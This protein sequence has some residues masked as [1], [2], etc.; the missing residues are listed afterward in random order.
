MR[1]RTV[2][3]LTALLLAVGSGCRTAPNE[4]ANIVYTVGTADDR[5]PFRL[6]EWLYR[7]PSLEERAYAVWLG[8]TAEI[9]EHHEDEVKVRC[10]KGGGPDQ[11]LVRRDVMPGEFVTGWVKRSKLVKVDPSNLKTHAEHHGAVDPATRRD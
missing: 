2:N 6:I 5:W 3:I 9:L 10:H 8:A 7:T 1:T 11:E 4:D